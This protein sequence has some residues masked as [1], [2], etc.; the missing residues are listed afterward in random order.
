MMKTGN[1]YRGRLFSLVRYALLAALLV[2]AKEALAVLPNIEIVTLLITVY[3]V[4]YRR[5]AL[6]PIYLFVAIETV[7]YPFFSTVV[8][9][10]YIW[11]VLWGLVMLL[12]RRILPAPVYMLIGG[13]YG[14]AFGTL[15]AP[16]Q[17]LMFFLD[18][19]GML[20]WIVAG[21]PF[22]VTHALSGFVTCLLVPPLA[23]LFLRL[24]SGRR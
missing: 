7:L 10:L 1:A 15:C 21:L 22:D 12:P 20:A 13:L 3:T 9:Y 23:R 16:A 5:R 18:F 8:M 11:A 19:K 24:E 2:A 6:V 4:V 17:A 14:L